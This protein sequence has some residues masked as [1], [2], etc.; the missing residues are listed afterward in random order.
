MLA[1]LCGKERARK[2]RSEFIKKK[3]VT[4][5]AAFFSDGTGAASVTKKI[6]KILF[7]QRTSRRKTAYMQ[8]QSLQRVILLV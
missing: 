2:N 5:V 6:R 3:A 8:T 7:F 1:F 4:K